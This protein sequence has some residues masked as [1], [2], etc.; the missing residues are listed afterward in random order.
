M[1]I[2]NIVTTRLGRLRGVEDANGVLSFKGIPYAATPIGELRWRAPQPH[3]GWRDVRDA[4]NYGPRCIAPPCLS[5]AVRDMPISEDSLFLD[6]WTSTQ[7][8]DAGRPVMVWIHGGGFQTGASAEPNHDGS[9]FASR[10]VVVVSINYRLGIV[11]FLAH[12]Q[13]DQEGA[14]SGNFGLQ[15]QIAALHW[16]R[17]NISEFGGD[18]ENVTIFGESAGAASVA[19]LMASPLAKGLFHRAISESGNFWEGRFGS[20]KTHEQALAQGTA[21]TERL[22]KSIEELR[23][24]PESQLLGLAPWGMPK[25]PVTEGFSPSIDGAVVPDHPLEIYQSGR[26]NDVPLLIGWNGAEGKTFAFWALP[27]ATTEDFT[28]DASEIFGEASLSDFLRHYPASTVVEAADS[29]IRLIGD[30]TV[31]EQSWQWLRQHCSTGS[32]S[33]YTYYFD[34][35]SD[36]T[37]QPVHTSEIDYVFGTLAP[38]QLGASA[39]PPDDRDKEISRQMVDYWINFAKGGDPNGDQ[40][41]YWP[42]YGLSEKGVMGFSYEETA[43][44]R[45]LGTARFEFLAG[46]R[47]GAFLPSRWRRRG[48]D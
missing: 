40:L 1:K 23:Q 46:F 13:L 33:V 15:D 8:F 3:G 24:V 5:P 7:H 12:P 34:V 16:V 6:I 48:T 28:A 44:G 32:S 25:D 47:S 9:H 29:A 11:G 22:G 35:R 45:E 26:Q 39:T 41:P 42:R 4:S 17:D 10:D 20:L 19:L 2:S 36:Y 30:Q 31:C 27:H 18:P 21:L 14:S 38:H 37:P 43:A